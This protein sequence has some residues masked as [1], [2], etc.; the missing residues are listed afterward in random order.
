MGIGHGGN[1]STQG[2][3]DKRNQIASA[4]DKSVC[5]RL[6]AAKVLSINCDDARKAKVDAV[7]KTVSNAIVRRK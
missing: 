6:E 5:S 2:L 7:I 4:E 3:E 1:C